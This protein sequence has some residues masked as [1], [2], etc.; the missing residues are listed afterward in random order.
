MWSV[1]WGGLLGLSEQTKGQNRG[2]IS[3]LHLPSAL[4]I[5]LRIWFIRLSL[6]G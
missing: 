5:H 3:I 4:I 2:H 1:R 6:F